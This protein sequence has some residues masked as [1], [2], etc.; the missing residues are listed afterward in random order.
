M[1]WIFYGGSIFLKILDPYSLVL[2]SVRIC[3][4]KGRS[5]TEQISTL[6][7]DIESLASQSY[8]V[9]AS[10]SVTNSFSELAQYKNM[11]TAVALK[12][13]ESRLSYNLYDPP[14]SFTP[15]PLNS[16]VFQICFKVL[17]HI[18][19]GI[20]DFKLTFNY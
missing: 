2:T 18:L 10:S 14:T 6:F 12:Y 13:F 15:T 16:V 19:F 7:L 20:P 17:L 5:S 1:G 8:A 9:S 4:A 3:L 11:L